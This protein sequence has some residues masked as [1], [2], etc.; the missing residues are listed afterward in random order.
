MLIPLLNAFSINMLGD[1]Q[2]SHMQLAGFHHLSF[3]DAQAILAPRWE[4]PS[5]DRPNGLFIPSF[6]SFVGHADT[7]RVLEGML[8][9]HV[10]CNRSNVTIAKNAIVAQ[11]VGPRLPEGA[12]SLPEGAKINWYLIIM[13]MKY[14][15][16][17]K[18]SWLPPIKDPS[19]ESQW[20]EVEP[21]PGT[22]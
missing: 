20:L 19:R 4:E 11:Y 8:K 2:V 1:L 9:L 13:G 10:P 12:T 22:R 21:E 15:P 7:A 17:P 18:S 6:E 5:P 14:R 16:R 3:E